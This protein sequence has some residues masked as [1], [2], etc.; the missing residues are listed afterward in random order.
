MLIIERN[1]SGFSN[2]NNNNTIGD[3]VGAPTSP[4]PGRI[5]IE[6]I[7]K[8]WSFIIPAKT[9]YPY[10]NNKINMKRIKLAIL[11]EFILCKNHVLIF[12]PL[13]V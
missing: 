5:E 3:F 10:S 12:L 13:Y 6:D 9:I 11:L 1:S 7:P 4:V 2:S 8:R